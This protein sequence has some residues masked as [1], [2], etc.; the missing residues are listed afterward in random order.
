MGGGQT[1]AL[2]RPLDIGRAPRTRDHRG[3]YAGHSAPPALQTL[4]RGLTSRHGVTV[5]HHNVTLLRYDVNYYVTKSSYNAMTLCNYV[6]TSLHVTTSLCYVTMSTYDTVLL[7]HN[8][9]SRH[10]ITLRRHAV[11]SCRHVIAS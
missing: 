9:T 10:A 6:I 3:Q 7:R 1:A 11:T 8:V 5:L 4:P 2:V